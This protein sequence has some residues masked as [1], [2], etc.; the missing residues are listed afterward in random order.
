VNCTVW[1]GESKA[2]AQ[3]VIEVAGLAALR[4]RIRPIWRNRRDFAQ[5]PV[6]LQ[7]ILYLDRPDVIVMCGEPQRPILAVE[8]CAEAPSGH[9]ICQRLARVAAAAEF[10]T[11]FAFVFPRRKWIVRQGA[12]GAQGRWDEYN[13]LPLQAMLQIAR[14]HATPVAAFFWDADEKRGRLTDGYLICDPKYEGL[15]HRR[16]GEM[17]EFR[18]FARLA[19]E[20]A[21][22]RRPPSELAWDPVCRDREVEMQKAYWTRAGDHGKKWSPLTDTHEVATT[23]GLG[24]YVKKH[25]GLKVELPEHVRGRRRSLIYTPKVTTFRSD[26]YAG[27]LVA[28]DYHE[29]RDGPTPRHRHKNLVL[30]LSEVSIEDAAKKFEAYY[31][32][33]CPLRPGAYGRADR[34][35]TLHLRDGC[36][37]T[38]QKELRVFCYLADLV[39][40][41]DA[42]LL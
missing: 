17:L 39:I 6:T 4:P 33:G 34:Y 27:N 32:T 37:Y 8:F 22:Q 15:P 20:A 40:F 28:L 14:F 9:N 42:V 30:H 10:G 18:R 29:C 16:S 25:T 35:L 23:P 19:V 3:Y 36:R 2:Q 26:P 1:Y 21:V 11:P 13:P 5:N 41:R 12:S 31:K 24:Q 7:K 38:K